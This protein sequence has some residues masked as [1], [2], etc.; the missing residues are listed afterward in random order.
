[1]AELNW[2]KLYWT[3]LSLVTLCCAVLGWAGLVIVL[4]RTWLLR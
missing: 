1:M 2:T 4:G 3:G